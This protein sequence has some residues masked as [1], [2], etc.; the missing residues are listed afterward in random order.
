MRKKFFLGLFIIVAICFLV[1]LIFVFRQNKNVYQP[2]QNIQAVIEI[3]DEDIVSYEEAQKIDK[4]IVAMFYVDWCG[5]CRK[6]MPVFGEITKQYKDKYT[7]AAINCDD[8]KYLDL[9]KDFHVLGFPSVYIVD[10]KIKHKFVLSPAV[11]SDISLL[12]EELDNYLD[13][14]KQLQK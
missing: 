12:K 14:R 10:N 13:V 7:F 6:F 2:Q 4:P 3:P 11:L 8:S 1:F 5:Y 9:M